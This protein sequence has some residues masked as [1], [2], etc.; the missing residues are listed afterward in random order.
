MQSLEEA[1]RLADFRLDSLDF[2][3]IVGLL[4]ELK[5]Y[6]ENYQRLADEGRRS[7]LDRYREIG[8][9]SLS[10]PETETIRQED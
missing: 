5:H 7:L 1:E 8:D 4:V 9:S 6:Q 2:P 3:V 10:V